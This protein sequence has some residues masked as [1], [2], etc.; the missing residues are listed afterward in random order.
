MRVEELSQGAYGIRCLACM[1]CAQYLGRGLSDAV[2]LQSL[3]GGLCTSPQASLL[4]SASNVKCVL[5]ICM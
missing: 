3:A 4:L 5:D 1:S 2:S